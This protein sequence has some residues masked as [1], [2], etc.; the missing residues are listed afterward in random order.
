MRS[1][2]ARVALGLLVL[3]ALPLRADDFDAWV[4]NR[5]EIRRVGHPTETRLPVG[6][7]QKP[8]VA[9]AWAAS[10]PTAPAPSFTCT[11]SS[12]CWRPAGHGTLDLRGALRESCNTYFRFL[13][14]ETEPSALAAA[15][16]AAGFDWSGE[17]TDAEAIGL[18]GFSP[19]TI[20]PE[21]LLASYVDL[22]R[23]PWSE[24]EDVRLEVLAGLRDAA[25]EGT[26]SG[27]GL[28]GF[29][30]KTGTVPAIDGTPLRTSGFA[31]VLDDAGFA[32][33][34]LLRNGTGRE[35]A[36][37]AGESIAKLRPGAAIR[38][39]KNAGALGARPAGLRTPR[40]KRGLEDPLEV[41][42]LEELRPREVRLRNLTAGPLDSSRGFVGPGAEVTVRS[43]DRF[44]AGLWEIKAQAP[45]FERRLRGSI[46]VEGG[47]G[48]F[49][50]VA[51]MTARDYANGVLKAELGPSTPGLRAQL[52]AAALRFVRRGQRHPNADV[53]D[54]THCAWF[55]GEGP[56]PRWIRPDAA[57][58]EKEA[59]AG[60][61]DAEWTRAVAAAR[62]EPR[63]VAQWTAD[64]GGDP[65]APHFVWGGGDRRV[66]ACTRHPRGRGR[67][68]KRTWPVAD[69]SAIF[70]AEPLSMEVVTLDGQ[71]FLRVKLTGRSATADFNYD[72]AHRRL[73][74]RLG[75]DSMPA[76]ASRVTRTAAGFTAEGVGFGHRVGLCLAP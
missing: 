41:L 53:C 62:S 33:L 71:W 32:F 28:W 21:R 10:H 76:P 73:A 66:N 70:G 14:R 72:D 54:S 8:F 56:V 15:F 5:G 25:Q 26:A 18:P 7:L 47:E 74:A 2:W 64:C 19:V 51:R 45:V 63:G 31:L 29:L 50:L 57:R 11:R 12:G 69:L 37:R 3:A 4:L 35:A 6:S 46:V 16:R 75:W 40:P 44:V 17:L 23:T 20:G 42:M 49:R 36:I 34:G 48:P 27:L 68:W 30:A 60:L 61:T 65:V 59:A 55:V 39:P 58:N 13:A 24:R 9:R 67:T 43:G 1:A 22:V 38:T 52:A